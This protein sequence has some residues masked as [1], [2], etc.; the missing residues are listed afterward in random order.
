MTPTTGG[1]AGTA[2][3]NTTMFHE[4]SQSFPFRAPHSGAHPSWDSLP[5]SACPRGCPYHK[6]PSPFSTWDLP[7]AYHLPK[8]PRVIRGSD[9]P[10][11]IP[12]SQGAHSDS[13]LRSIC[14]PA[15]YLFVP[16]HLPCLVSHMP[17]LDPISSFKTIGCWRTGWVWGILHTQ[18]HACSTIESRET[19][20]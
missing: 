9:L 11:L 20:F 12:Q 3:R 16:L 19:R 7:K 4:Q 18:Q 8:L 5:S 1:T 2:W 17:F 6:T 10:Q 13:F 14:S 15:M